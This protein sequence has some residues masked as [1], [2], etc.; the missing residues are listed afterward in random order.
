MTKGSVVAGILLAPYIPLLLLLAIGKKLFIFYIF[1]YFYFRLPC[2][3]GN[4]LSLSLYA[5]LIL[6]SQTKIKCIFMVIVITEVIEGR[7]CSENNIIVFNSFRNRHSIYDNVGCKTL[8][9]TS[10]PPDSGLHGISRNRIALL[11]SI[12]PLHEDRITI[13]NH[14]VL[15]HNEY[16]VLGHYEFYFLFISK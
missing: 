13:W 16:K 3:L 9:M 11:S 1:L 8:P 5:Y 7:I 2:V 12:R 15:L 10:H 14:F 4:A 6:T